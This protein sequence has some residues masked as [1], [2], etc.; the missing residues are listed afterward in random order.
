VVAVNWAAL[1]D[2]AVIGIGG[3]ALAGLVL[4]A[5]GWFRD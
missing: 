4:W 1:A 5:A 3:T 2:L